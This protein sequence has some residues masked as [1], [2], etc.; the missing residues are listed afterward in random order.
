MGFGS[1]PNRPSELLSRN[2]S[3][4]RFLEMKPARRISRVGRSVSRSDRELPRQLG[5]HRTNGW[6]IEVLRSGSGPI[7]VSPATNGLQL[8]TFITTSNVQTANLNFA[9]LSPSHARAAQ[10][11]A[12]YSEDG[13]RSERTRFVCSAKRRRRR[14]LR[15]DSIPVYLGTVETISN[16]PCSMAVV[17]EKS[18][19]NVSP[20]DCFSNA[21]R[22][23]QRSN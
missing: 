8:P 2:D 16:G 23:L 12:S 3:Y 15:S 1:V 22:I 9:R 5:D 6:P 18:V 13:P 21:I 11:N 4:F 20:I 14:K 7:L 10:Q 17:L 19:V